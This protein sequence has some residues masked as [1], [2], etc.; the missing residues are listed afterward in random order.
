MNHVPQ[1]VP[2][3]ELRMQ[4]VRV[5]SLLDR[6]PVILAQRSR[7][8]AVLVSLNDWDRMADEL[9]RLRRIIEGDRQFA[10]MRAGNYVDLED[11]DKALAAT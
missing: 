8:A 1:I 10:E 2:V 5:F 9:S 11:L 4:H 3:S 7:P 6:G